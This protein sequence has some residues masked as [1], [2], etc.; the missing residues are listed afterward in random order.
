MIHTYNIWRSNLVR[1]NQLDEKQ[2]T[3]VTHRLHVVSKT[4]WEHY[5]GK[6]WASN[7]AT[8]THMWLNKLIKIK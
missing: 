6:C 1:S 3:G 8:A 5:F 7:A 4:R 2:L